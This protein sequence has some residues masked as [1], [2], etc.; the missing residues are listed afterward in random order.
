[1]KRLLFFLVLLMTGQALYAQ[2]NEEVNLKEVTVEA[3]KTITKADGRLIF[4]SKSQKEAATNGYSLLGKL[5]LPSIRVDEVLH[6]VTALDHQGMVQVRINGAIASKAEL[7]GLNPK[8]VRNVDFIDTPGVRYGEGVAY[9]IDIRTTRADRGYTIGADLSNTLTAWNGNDAVYGKVNVGKSEIGLTYNFSYQDFRGTRTREEADYLL[10]DGTHYLVTRQDKSDRSR[11]FNHTVQL[12]YNLADSSNYVFQAILSGDWG[13]VPNNFTERAIQDGTTSYLSSSQYHNRNFSPTLDLYFFRKLGS[14]QTFT[15]N[16]VATHISNDSHSADTEGGY[17]AYDV[18]GRTWSLIS[19]GIYEN[20]FKPFTL[21]VGVKHLI[22]YT[23]NNYRGD[24]SSINLL[25]NSNLY[26]FV[27][28]KGKIGKWRYVGGLGVS[29]ARYSQSDKHYNFWLFR[30][31]ATLAYDLTDGLML[32]YSFELLQYTSQVAMISDTR[33]RQ[34]SREWIVGNPNIEPNRVITHQW[35]LAFTRPRL[36]SSL[37]AEY[38]LNHHPNMAS[39]TRSADNQF[40]YTQVNQR[41]INMFYVRGYAQYDVV[42]NKLTVT[43]D[44][45]I[46]RFFNIGNDYAHYL[47]TYNG[48]IA[49]QAYLGKWTLTAFADTGWKFMEGETRHHFATTADLTCSYR[50]GRC[51]ISLY[52]QHPFNAHPRE[53]HE[54]LVNQFIHKNTTQRIR[55]YGNMITLNL[56]WKLNKGKKTVDIQ[57][58]IDNKDNQTGILR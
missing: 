51:D 18:A 14:H 47:T 50:L 13:H 53:I 2:E 52:W 1:M 31:K 27:E 20:Q 26:S 40:F 34:N 56:S 15:A 25:H 7:L 38:R 57:K 30:P 5:A 9:I 29:N 19:E 16:M 49:V 12:K 24:V 44:G 48:N 35:V 4:P 37:M 55:E 6:T 32:K 10:N 46:Y 36:S 58:K 8:I 41:H 23:K 39:Y 45:G 54:G 43:A 42:P 28:L 11:Q 22:K 21:S 3:A 33:I 17:Y